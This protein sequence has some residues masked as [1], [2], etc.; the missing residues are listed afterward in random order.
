MKVVCAWCQRDGHGVVLRETEPQDEVISH[1]I[2]DAHAAVVMAEVRRTR[3]AA[4]VL[5]RLAS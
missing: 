2:C 1:G 5:E 3:P 4:S